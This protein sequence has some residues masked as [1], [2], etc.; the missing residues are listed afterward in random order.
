MDGLAGSC[1]SLTIRHLTAGRQ[2]E[3]GRRSVKMVVVTM[4][5]TM[6]MKRRM[7]TMTEM[8]TMTAMMMMMMMT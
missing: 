1:A 3:M 2:E 6:T 7:R 4:G 8:M 5:R